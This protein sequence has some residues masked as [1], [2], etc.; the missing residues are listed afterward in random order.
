LHAVLV[1][2][3]SLVVVAANSASIM[4]SYR[5]ALAARK[6]PAFMEFT[7]TVTRS[8]PNRI[9]TEQHRVYW[10]STGDE[11]N[12]TIEVNGSPVI[13]APS[14]VL[15]RTPW[16]YDPGQFAVSADDYDAVAAGTVVIAGRM[17]YAFA[18]SRN[19]AADFMLKS[20]YVDTKTR[21]PVRQTF[22][23]VGADCEGAGSINFVPV[24]AYWLPGFV[25]V[26]CTA[27]GSAAS[28]PP[29]Y[30]ESIRFTNYQFPNTI[31]PD[32]FGQVSPGT[33][34]DTPPGGP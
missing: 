34:D 17:T 11:R 6:V 18:L 9:V 25:S 32:V 5:A 3:A 8:G 19:S 4:D 13:P 20:L 1:I 30:K 22:A 10:A 27:S 15:H 28:P 23:V 24:G 31:P 12:D 14:H 26:V 7:Y 16:P 21:L 2:A 33:S 29:I